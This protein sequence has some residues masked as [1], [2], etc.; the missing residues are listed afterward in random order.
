M[1]SDTPNFILRGARLATS[2]VSLPTRSC[3]W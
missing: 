2:T 1:P 3:G